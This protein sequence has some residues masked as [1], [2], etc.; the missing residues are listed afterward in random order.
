MNDQALSLGCTFAVRDVGHTACLKYSRAVT[1]EQHLALSLSLSPHM[2]SFCQIY[3]KKPPLFP[4]LRLDNAA[5]KKAIPLCLNPNYGKQ[6]S[7]QQRFSNFFQ[8]GTTFI[9]QNVLRTT[10]LLGLSNSLGLP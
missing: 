8:V 4:L 5:V 7:L 2:Q 6:H 10:L 1:A 3:I 9:S